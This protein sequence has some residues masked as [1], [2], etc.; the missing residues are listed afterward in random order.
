MI[1]TT[2][3]CTKCKQTKNIDFF[4]RHPDTRDGYINKCKEC[5]LKYAST[6]ILNPDAK[7]RKIEL[8]KK[9]NKEKQKNPVFKL[10]PSIY[11]AIS[12]GCKKTNHKKDQNTLSVLGLNSWDEFRK[13]IESQFT[14]GMNW[15]NY[16]VGKDNSTWH[17]DHIKP[18]SLATNIDESKKINHYTNLRPMWGSDNQRKSN[19][20]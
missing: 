10:Q 5:T 17:I 2:K 16:G 15:E 9:Y 3:V 18:I 4:Y 6:Y 7:K 11:N 13:H 14:K 12:R 1:N 19:F 8:N 20:Y